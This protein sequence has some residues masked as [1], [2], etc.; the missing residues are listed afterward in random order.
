MPRLTEAIDFIREFKKANPPADKQAV[1]A[2]FVARFQPAKRRSVFV[3]GNFAIRFCEANAGSFSNVVLSLSA[4]QPFDAAP[5]VVCVVRPDAI[6]F[7]LANTTFLNKISHSSKLLR[8]DKL[9]GSFLGSN[10]MG[11]YDG[12]PNDPRN[13]AHLFEAHASFTWVENLTRLVEA[14]NNIAARDTRFKPS[15]L[16]RA[17]IMSAPERASATLSSP[18][19]SEIAKE[20]DETIKM[21]AVAI[22]A[23]AKTDNVNLRGNAIEQAVTGVGNFHGLGDAAF[24]LGGNER[25]V[26]DIKTKLMDRGSAPKAY[27]IDKTLALL[28]EPGSVF[29]FLILGIDVAA[30]SIATRLIPILDATL[31]ASTS[32]QHHWAGRG[33]RG[34]TQLSGNFGQV[35]RAAYVPRIDIVQSRQFLTNLLAL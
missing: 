34:V 19:F 8:V 18:R 31:L 22:V 1:V 12:I 11:H 29:A 14:T 9:R 7:M 4:L 23:A 5:F 32:V 20:F 27:N 13:F 28:A 35:L 17:T 6:G 33:S 21:Q 26:V 15:P 10:I 24:S 25:L 30:G 3:C 16:Q 2:A